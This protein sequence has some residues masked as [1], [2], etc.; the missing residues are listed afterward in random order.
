MGIDRPAKIFR[1]TDGGAT[2]ARTFADD[3]PGV[4]LDGLAFFADGGKT[5]LAVADRLWEFR[6]TQRYKRLRRRIRP[7]RIRRPFPLPGGSP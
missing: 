5:W 6:S 4:F 2:W 3:S 1:T 7:L